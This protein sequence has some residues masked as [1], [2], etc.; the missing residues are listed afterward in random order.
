MSGTAERL[1]KG[2]LLDDFDRPNCWKA[3]VG[4][5]ERI[6]WEW[7]FC[8][9]SSYPLRMLPREGVEADDPVAV[10]IISEADRGRW[11]R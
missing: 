3:V 7:R 5:G 4:D 2:M 8:C 11:C 1:D 6:W 9:F 10:V